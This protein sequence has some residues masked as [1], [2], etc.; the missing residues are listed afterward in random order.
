M[1]NRSCAVI[2]Y[3][4]ARLLKLHTQRDTTD[5]LD[6]FTNEIRRRCFWSCWITSCIS[7]DNANFRAE[8]WKEVV[9]LAFPSDEDSYALSLPVSS[10]AF[11]EEGNIIYNEASNINRQPSAMGELVKLSCVWYISST[12]I[13]SILQLLTIMRVQVGDSTLCQTVQWWKVK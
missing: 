9:G 13:I 10:G 2:A 4:M 3:K 7:Q 1:A 12:S 6:A 8:P 11:D 5:E